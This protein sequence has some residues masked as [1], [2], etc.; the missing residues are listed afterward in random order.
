MSHPV[1]DAAAQ[2]CL[3]MGLGML[4]DIFCCIIPPVAHSAHEINLVSTTGVVLVLGLKVVQHVILAIV[5]NLVIAKL[6]LNS[7]KVPWKMS[8]GRV[9]QTF[10]LVVFNLMRQKRI[11]IHESPPLF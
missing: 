5:Q 4:N 3:K 1:S 9:E 8:V 7:H 6:A 10:A 11:G 2:A